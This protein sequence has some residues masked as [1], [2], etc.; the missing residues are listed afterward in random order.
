MIR[1]FFFLF[2]MVMYLLQNAEFLEYCYLR[3]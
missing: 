1:V 3:H 2:I